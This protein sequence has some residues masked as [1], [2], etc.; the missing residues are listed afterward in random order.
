MFRKCAERCEEPEAYAPGGFPLV[1]PF[2]I[3]SLASPWL[4]ALGDAT[5][6]WPRFY[7]W[8]PADLR[9]DSTI[10]WEA[11]KIFISSHVIPKSPSVPTGTLDFVIHVWGRLYCAGEG[12]ARQLTVC[13]GEA[14]RQS[15]G[16]Y[17]REKDEKDHET[18]RDP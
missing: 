4:L 13:L 5:Q 12:I 1:L 10:W 2:T 7:S 9:L 14:M 3:S 18:Y 17:K 16:V 8:R 11:K 6:L 15:F